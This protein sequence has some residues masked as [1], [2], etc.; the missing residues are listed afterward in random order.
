M[1][2]LKMSY[3][4][5]AVF[6][7]DGGGYSVSFPDLEGCYTYAE[8]MEEAALNAK[9]ALELY[10][11]VLGTVPFYWLIL[12]AFAV[13]FIENIFPPSPSDLILVAVAIIS[14]IMLNIEQTIRNTI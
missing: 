8:T 1:D 2:N 12:I 14:G 3:A 6:E 7:K 4:Y 10:I 13:T 11:E 9:E 5:P